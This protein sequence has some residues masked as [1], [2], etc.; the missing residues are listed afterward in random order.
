IR[1]P[2]FSVLNITYTEEA[3]EA[4][5]Q[6]D[7]VANVAFHYVLLYFSPVAVTAN[8]LSASLLL[9]KELRNPFNFL[10]SL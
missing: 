8:I 2:G 4:F 10:L 3:L 6:V 5:E 7:I 1:C 9:M